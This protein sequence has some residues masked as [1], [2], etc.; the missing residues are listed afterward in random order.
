MIPKPLISIILPAYN[1]EALIEHTVRNA[2]EFLAR[3]RLH[4]EIVVVN[5][6]SKDRTE[7]VL[8]RLQTTYPE[9]R[10]VCHHP[11]V[12]Y[13]GAVTTGLLN[14]R[15]ELLFFTDGDGQF[16]IEEL[17]TFLPY[18]DHHDLVIGYRRRRADHFIRTLNARIFRLAVLVLFGFFVRDIDCAFKLFR[19]KVFKEVTPL[20]SRGALFSAEFLIKARRL[21]FRIKE[22]PVS[23]YPRKAGRET[24]ASLAVILKAFRELLTLRV[25]MFY[26]RPRTPR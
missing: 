1:E 19:R 14:G 3:H 17:S 6:G 9:L 22:L 23:H 21:G 16:D 8:R 20:T 7:E 12:G 18:L 24:G 26:W 25:T 13:G 4:G 15:G 5:D 2:S 10:V 11:N